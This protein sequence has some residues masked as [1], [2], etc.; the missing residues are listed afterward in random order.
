MSEINIDE[1]KEY[2][3]Q[4]DKT[5]EI[6]EEIGCF[7]IK[8][9]T[10]EYRC[11]SPKHNNST[12]IS[13]KKDTLKIKIYGKDN[14][15]RGDLITLVMDIK[16]IIFPDAIKYI[17]QILGLKYTG[18]I[19]KKKEDSNK[20]D[21]LKI[22]KKASKEYV[23]YSDEELKI[24]NEDICSEFIKLP[25]IDWVREGI[26]PKT[27]DIFG[28]GYSKKSNRAIIPHRY[29]SGSNNDYVGVIGRTLVKNYDLFDIPKYFPLQRFPKG[30]NIYGLQENYKGIQE[31]G[32][33]SVY[34]AEKSVLK[35]HSRLDYTGVALGSHEI[36]QRQAEILIS[37]DVDIVIVMDKDIPLQH[38][39][40]LCEMFYGIRP[41]Y[42]IYDNFGLLV[43]KESP[44]DKPDRVY[45]VLFNRKIRYDEE[46]HLKYLESLKGEE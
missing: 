45:K 36:T 9:Y 1:L 28:I 22:F 27:Q 15:I 30:M 6:L 3:V 43:D 4:N 10:K 12:S 11:G 18:K 17:H 8:S 7:N 20:I 40:S 46:E 29:W 37:L 33:V 19:Y 2:I 35:R 21:I 39:R 42:Y 5:K 38:I 26:L 23:D 41:I 25:Y 32:Y 13:I 24:F 34:E 14:K 16:E 31:S 44:A